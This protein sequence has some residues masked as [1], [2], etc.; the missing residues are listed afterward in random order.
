MALELT[1]FRRGTAEKDLDLGDGMIVHVEYH[2]DWYTPDVLIKTQ[3][4]SKANRPTRL[5]RLKARKQPGEVASR[6]EIEMVR[7]MA[8]FL[9]DTIVDWDLEDDGEPYA[10]T[11]S[12][13]L[14]LPGDLMARIFNALVTNQQPGNVNGSNSVGSS[15]TPDEGSTQA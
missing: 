6:A 3:E 11:A 12:N 1:D 10:I 5:S 13:M 7:W 4:F 8:D 9:T 2:I 15:S 14:K